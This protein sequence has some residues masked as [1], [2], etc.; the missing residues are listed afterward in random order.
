M[1][2]DPN[3]PPHAMEF[4]GRHPHGMQPVAPCMLQSAALAGVASCPATTLAPAPRPHRAG[5]RHTTPL[6]GGPCKGGAH[7]AH[8]PGSAGGGAPPRGITPVHTSRCPQAGQRSGGMSPRWAQAGCQSSLTGTTTGAG[9][10]A[11]DRAPAPPRRCDD[12][13]HR[14]GQP[15][16]GAPAHAAAT[17]G[18][19]P[20]GTTSYATAGW[21]QSCTPQR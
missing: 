3:C 15:G 9:L 13:A 18:E 4:S 2:P 12:L 20:R 7:A 11:S 16:A 6:A 1:R 21:L 8:T 10:P 14:S 17:V 19:S 5:P